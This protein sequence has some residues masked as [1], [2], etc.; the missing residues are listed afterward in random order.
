[1]HETLTNEAVK[2]AKT[3]RYARGASDVI[4]N[5]ISFVGSPLQEFPS[6]F[7]L[8]NVP[9]GHCKTQVPWYKKC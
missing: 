8:D 4:F 9:A 7:R 1:M 6:D 5:K 3:N 2:K